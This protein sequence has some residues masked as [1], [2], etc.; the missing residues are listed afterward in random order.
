MFILEWNRSKHLNCTE[1]FLLHSSKSENTSLNIKSLP[2]YYS[3]L[4]FTSVNSDASLFH[5]SN[6]CYDFSSCAAWPPYNLA[7][8]LPSLL[9][10]HMGLKALRIFT[11]SSPN[12]FLVSILGHDGQI[13]LNFFI[14]AC[15]FCH[16]CISFCLCFFL[17]LPL[18]FNFYL[19]VFFS[20]LQIML[21]LH[22][23]P[24]A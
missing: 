22:I 4:Y 24:L 10:L 1:K 20:S 17:F 21:V 12:L 2:P 7:S 3:V 13:L 16:S 11:P 6:V 19:L 15:N 14:C 8:S 5:R 23:C 9:Q 18:S